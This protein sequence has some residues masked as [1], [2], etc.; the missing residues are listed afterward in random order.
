MIPHKIHYCWFGYNPKPKLIQKCIAS[1]QRMNPEWEIIEWNESNY[2]INKIPYIAEAYKQKK[3]AFVVD[4]ARFDILNSEGG[5][6]LDA[7]VECL[8]PFPEDMLELEAFTGFENGMKIAPGLAFGAIPGQKMLSTIIDYYTD[9]ISFNTSETICD[10]VTGILIK[11][12]LVLNDSEQNIFGIKVFPSSYFCCFD[13]ETQSFD[14]QDWTVSIHHYYASWSPWY[15][16]AYFRCIKY[17]AKIL[18]KER[19]IRIKNKILGR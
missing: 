7:D 12:G 14:I 3:W 2:D 10:I 8:R 17:M 15:R 16:K 13:H 5:I 4:F 11:N 19:Y 6:F 1:W 18:G 9:R